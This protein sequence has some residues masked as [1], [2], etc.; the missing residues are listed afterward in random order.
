MISNSKL[1]AVRTN[2]FGNTV[3][4]DTVYGAI[5]KHYKTWDDSILRLSNFE[6]GLE[7]QIISNYT[8]MRV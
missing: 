3:S 7:D 6:P 2:N 8:I 4:S 1:G 5:N